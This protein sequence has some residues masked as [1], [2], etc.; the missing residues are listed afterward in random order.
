MK[1]VWSVLIT[2]LGFILKIAWGAFKLVI[3]FLSILFSVCSD[4]GRN[5][6]I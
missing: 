5:I 4:V 6:K 3:V 2:I 1:K